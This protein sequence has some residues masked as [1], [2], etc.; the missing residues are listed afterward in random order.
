[1]TANFFDPGT[2]IGRLRRACYEKLREHQRD[3]A[4]P[5][6]G[7]FIFYELEQNGVVPKKYPAPKKRTPPKTS[8]TH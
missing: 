6:N 7:R 3:G 8:A 2:M 5:T 1:M 4:L